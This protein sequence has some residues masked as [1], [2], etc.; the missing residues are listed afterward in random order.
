M[1]WCCINIIKLLTRLL[2]LCLEGRLT[3]ILPCD[4]CKHALQQITLLFLCFFL[5]I[6]Q[7]LMMNSMS[8]LW[9]RKCRGPKL[10]VPFILISIRS[11]L[12]PVSKA[13]TSCFRWRGG[14]PSWMLISFCTSLL[15]TTPPTWCSWLTVTVIWDVCMGSAPQDLTADALS[16]VASLVLAMFSGTVGAHTVP[17]EKAIICLWYTKVN[18]YPDSLA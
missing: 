8:Y 15:L 17:W 14:H 3:S 11:I 1:I 10:Q 5:P 18:P 6:S 7:I 4:F 2:F 12:R 16:W 9:G 13:F